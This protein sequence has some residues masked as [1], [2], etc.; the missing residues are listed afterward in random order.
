MSEKHNFPTPDPDSG[1]RVLHHRVVEVESICDHLRELLAVAR[2][3]LTTLRVLV[4]ILEP[5]ARLYVN[6]FADDESMTLAERLRL[7][8]VEDAL[9]QLDGERV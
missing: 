5:V 9:A 6:A 4:D 1:A 7:Q 8:A 2:K 3:E